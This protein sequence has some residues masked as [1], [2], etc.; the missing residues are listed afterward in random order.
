MASDRLERIRAELS[1]GGDDGAS[2]SRLCQVSVKVSGVT[3]AGIMLMSGDFPT[4]SLCATDEVSRLIEDLQFSLGEGPCVQ[5]HQSDQ[6]VAEPD[7][8]APDRPR[9]LA[10]TPPAVGAGVRALFAF[11]LRVGTV[12]LG[13]LNLYRD[14]PGPLSEDQHADALVMADVAA[15]WV[16]E[17]QANAPPDKVAQEFELAGDFHLVVHNAAGMVSV[18][19]GISLAEALV[20]LRAHAFSAARDLREVAEDVVARRLRFD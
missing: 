11:P 6:V 10:F 5:A 13:A 3:G 19:A 2:S 20:R 4:G 9:W 14:C 7:L 18:Q 8:V 15:R 1:A 16:L 17:R 12:R